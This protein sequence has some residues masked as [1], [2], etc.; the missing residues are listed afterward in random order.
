M[1]RISFNSQFRLYPAKILKDS[2][3]P[4]IISGFYINNFYIRKSSRDRQFTYVAVFHHD[5]DLG[6]RSQ[7]FRMDKRPSRPKQGHIVCHLWTGLCVEI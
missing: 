3:L 6:E 1:T 2:G 4:L 5:E 7:A